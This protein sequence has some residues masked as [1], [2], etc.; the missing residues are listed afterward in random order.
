MPRFVRGPVIGAIEKSE[1]TAT[2]TSASPDLLDQVADFIGMK[3]NDTAAYEIPPLRPNETPLAA[4][5]VIAAP[6]EADPSLSDEAQ[7]AFYLEASFPRGEYRVPPDG[8]HSNVEIP[9]SGVPFGR[10]YWHTF[11]EYAS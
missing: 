3:P 10:S 5:H 11:F 1:P 6:H 9:V 8:A 7:D 2:P 4:I